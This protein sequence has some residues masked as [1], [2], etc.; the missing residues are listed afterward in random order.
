MISPKYRRS[1]N[2][3]CSKFHLSGNNKS[4]SIFC[5]FCQLIDKY[6]IKDITTRQSVHKS[7]LGHVIVFVP[8]YITDTA[9]FQ[10]SWYIQ[11]LRMFWCPWIQIPETYLYYLPILTY[12]SLTILP[13]L[14]YHYVP[15]YVIY[16][17]FK[18]WLND[19]LIK[20]LY[21]FQIAEKYDLRSKLITTFEVG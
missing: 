5:I 21:L 7:P 14:Q 12:P 8:R 6:D 15:F 3:N 9:I 16:I 1:Q 11:I 18:W 4:K 17:L 19:V 20:N 13:Y 2:N 10:I